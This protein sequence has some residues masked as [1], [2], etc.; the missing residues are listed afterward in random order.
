MRIITK[1]NSL[2]TQIA[3]LEA[4]DSTISGTLVSNTFTTG[5][6]PAGIAITPNGRYAYIANNNNYLLAGQDN[7]SVVDLQTGFS[8]ATINHASFNQP[9][10]VT[11]NATGT[12]A[13]ITNSNTDTISIINIATNTVIGTITGFDGP[14]GMVINGTTAY[15]NNYGAPGGLGSGNGTT[16]SVVNLNTNTITGTITVDQAPASLALTPNGA[17]VYVINYVDGNVGTGT[18]SIIQTSTNTVVGTITGFS[19]PFGIAITPN[20]TKAY[21]TN[22]GINNFTP[23]GTTVSVVS[24]STNAIIATI[25]VGIQPSGIAISPDGNYA[26]VSNYN[27]LYNQ[28]NSAPNIYQ[29]VSGDGTVNI[30]NTS[31]NTLVGKTIVVGRSPANIA[32]SGKSVYVTNYTSNTVSVIPLI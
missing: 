14:S 16:I 8:V 12:L 18:I 2:Q 32:I 31:T 11:I 28:I 9:Y 13:Y 7:V 24:L 6:N 26:Y 25:N 5:V 20:G 30:I 29:L 23:F 27:S 17:Y 21:I 10:T 15:V 22:F 1:Y 19:G 3:T 4:F